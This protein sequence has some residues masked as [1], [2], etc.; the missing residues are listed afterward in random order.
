MEKYLCGIYCIENINNNKLRLSDYS[1]D[2]VLGNNP[3]YIKLRIATT[4]TSGKLIYLD[5][6][7]K[8][9]KMSNSNYYI[10]DEEEL[11]KSETKDKFKAYRD[12]T[13]SEY[14]IFTNKSSG[15]LYIVA[16]LETIDSFNYSYETDVNGDKVILKF[17][18]MWTSKNWDSSQKGIDPKWVE[19]DYELEG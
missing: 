12:K 7:I 4:D 8:W 11:D 10:L 6:S 1:S 14:S 3:K 19:Y 2:K 17:Y 13:S 9:Y 5:S 18:E 15:E 16:E